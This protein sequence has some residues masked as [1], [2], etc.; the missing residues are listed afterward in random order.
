MD[1][2]NHRKWVAVTTDEAG[3]IVPGFEIN[4]VYEAP[5][6]KDIGANLM[7]MIVGVFLIL[8][9]TAVIITALVA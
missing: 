4:H 6:P 2:L 1:E 3:K 8:G 5:P 7:R 9:I